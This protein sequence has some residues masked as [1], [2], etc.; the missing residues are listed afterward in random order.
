M[1]EGTTPDAQIV[2]TLDPG[3]QYSL[4]GS[5][6]GSGSVSSS[7]GAFSNA[8]LF[9]PSLVGTI[10]GDGS[11][12]NP[13]VI[14]F[15]LGDLTNTDTNNGVAETLRLVYLATA[16][17]TADNSSH[18]AAAGD[19]KNNAAALTWDLGGASRE[20]TGI[21]SAPTLEIV[22]PELQIDKTLTSTSPVDAGD[23]VSW[24]VSVQ[25][26]AN[27][28]ADAYDATLQDPLPST[29]DFVGLLATHSTLGNVSSLFEFDSGTRQVRTIPGQSFDLAPGE[30]LT[31]TVDGIVN[32][33]AEP[34][35]VI[36][37]QAEVQ[38][39]SLEADLLDGD[40][41]SERNGTGGAVN[42]YLA[43]AGNSALQINSPT[44]SKLL[45]GS[46]VTTAANTAV[47]VALGETAQYRLTLT[48]PEGTTQGAQWFDSLDAGLQFVQVDSVVFSS[49]L[50]SSQATFDPAVIVNGVTFAQSLVFDLGTLTNMD[51]NNSV[52]ETVTID[53]SVRV[54]NVL[55]NQGVNSP[56]AATLLQNSAA[57]NWTVNS[58][59]H[60]LPAVQA[61][62][63][64][65]IEPELQLTKTVD[66]TT[67][68]L[69]ATLTY[70]LSINHDASSST[71]AYDVSLADTLPSFVTLN[72]G[73]ILAVGANI[74]ANASAGN[75]LAITLDSLALGSIAT[76]TY[77]AVV[78]SNPG[79]VGASINNTARMEWT[80]LP[81]S[82][83]TER[84]GSGGALNDY[85]AVDGASA[86]ITQPVLHV[87]KQHTGVTANLTNPL[88]W[89]VAVRVVAMNDGNVDLFNL[90]LLDDLQAHFGA[91]LVSVTAPSV[92][93]SVGLI[94]GGSVP[95][96]NP[97]WDGNLAGSGNV[98]VFNGSS[99][100][101][102]PGEWIAVTFV[103]TMDPDASGAT[104]PLANQVD[105]EADFM[106][107]G[108]TQTVTDPSDSGTNPSG[109]NPGQPG[110]TGGSDD[111]TPLY[112][113]DIA[114]TKS[115]VGVP[116]QLAND[117]FSVTYE[118]ALKNT[119]SVDI[120]D[121]Q[122]TEDMVNEFG[123]SVFV[124][125]LAAPSL[126]G[127]PSQPGSSAATFSSPAWDGNLGASGRVNLFDGSSGRLLP[128]DT[129]LIRFT[130]EV[131]PDAT[132]TSMPLDN[133]VVASATPLDALGNPLPSGTV[134]DLS[135]SGTNPSTTNPST[136]GDSG[137][138]DDPTPLAI[139]DIGLAKQV[140]NVTEVLSGIYDVQY[141]VVLENTGT[142]SVTNLQISEDLVAE[143][144]AA[145]VGIQTAASITSSSLSPGA[146]L[147]G[148]AS[149]AW[150][151]NLAGS[152]NTDFFDGSSGL[153]QP[154]DWLVLTFTARVNTNLGDTTPP[155]D[156]TNQ[157]DASAM[158]PTGLT[159]SD[160]SDDGT[161]P[162]TDNGVGGSDDPSPFTVPM[163][164]ATKS[165]G[166]TTANADGS[167]TV[168]VQILVENS[169]TTVLTDLSLREDITA[170]FGDALI[171]ITNPQI[172]AMGTYTGVL[173]LLN[174]SW[175]GNTT[176]DVLQPT[177]LTES[178]AVGEA[179]VF[180][181]DV[182][183]DPDR[184]DDASQLMFN[185]AL[186]AGMGLNFD[187]NTITVSDVS[188]ANTAFDLAGVD[189]DQPSQLL[190]PE[191]RVAKSVSSIVSVGLDYAVTFAITVENTG[192]AS[193][194]GWN[195]IDDLDAAFGPAFV[196]VDQVTMDATGVGA[197]VA[198]TLNFG[199][200][201]SGTPYDGGQALGSTDLLNGD[202]SLFPGEYFT[203]SLTMTL[204]PESA[205]S[206]IFLNQS[207]AL[208]I[209]P[210]S[211]PV[212]DLSDS[213][214][215]PNT[216][217]PGAVN[218]SGGQDDPT[219]IEISDIA[220][221]K[222][223]VGLP[224]LL[225][226]DHY[227]AVFEITLQNAGTVDVANLQIVENLEAELGSQVFAGVLAAPTL[228]AGTSEV[229]S[230]TPS[231][232]PAWDGG[233][234]A[235]ANVNLFVPS[236]ATRLVP[237]DSLTLQFTIEID[238][239]ASGASR[240]LFNQV[241]ASGDSLGADGSSLGP[242]SD[243]SDSGTNPNSTNAGAPGDL[244]TADD[245]TPVEIPSIRIAKQVNFA[246]PTGITG[247]FD[248]QYVLVVENTGS[249][250]LVSLQL[251]EDLSAEFGL[252]FVALQNVPMFT[253]FSLSPGGALPNLDAA[254]DGTAVHSTLLDGAS[255]NLLP[256]DSFSMT[257]TVRLDAV[258]GDTTAPVDFTNQIVAR[259]DGVTSGGLITVSDLSDDG[260]NPNTNNGM[261]GTN[262]RTGLQSPQVRVGKTYGAITANLDGTYTVP[263]LIQVVNT[264]TA[265]VTDLSLT[266]DL[267]AEFGD[268]F[269]NLLNPQISAI[270]AYAGE[271]PQL[272][273]NWN[274][275]NTSVDIIDPAQSTESLLVGESFLLSFDAVVDPDAVDG[276]SQYLTNQATVAGQST[277]FDGSPVMVVDESGAPTP[278]DIFGADLDNPAQ[279]LI[280]EVRSTKR[281]TMAIPVA[282]MWHV[283][284]EL[285]VENTGSTDLSNINLTDDL[286]AQW[287]SVFSRVISVSLDATDVGLGTAPTLNFGATAGSNPFD[288]GRASAASANLLNGDGLLNPGE[289]VLVTMI[290]AIDP[291]ATGT[292]TMLVNQAQT[293]ATGPTSTV[294]DLSDDGSN[295][296]TDN[297]TAVGDSGTG[298]H[299]DPTPIRIG[300]IAVT[301]E[302]IGTPLRL[303]NGNFHVTYQL[304]VENIGTLDLTH[305]QVIEDLAGH[306]GTGVLVN[307]VAAPAVTSGPLNPMSL[308][309][310][311]TPWD[312]GLGGNTSL[313][314]GT[315]GR[316]VP[317]DG[318]TVEFAVE[319]DPDA[320]GPA[321][322]YFN[323]V[324]ASADDAAGS[325]VTDLSD[326]GNDP[327]T[328]NPTAAGDQGTYDDPTPLVLPGINASKQLV[329]G[330]TILA[331][332]STLFS[333]TYEVQ[334][335]NTGNATLGGLDL[336]DD[337][338]SQFG[339][340][341]L[342]ITAAP[343]I[344]AHTLMSAANLP[345]LNP[346]WTGD[347]S[348]SLF[349]DDGTIH[350][351]ESIT[352]R[353]TVQL[354]SVLVNGMTLLNQAIA[355]ADDPTSGLENGL[356]DLSD[357]GSDPR[358][359]NTGS[360]GDT[361]GY[362]DPTPTI[363][364]NSIVGVAKTSTWD[365]V[366]DRVTFDFYLEHLGV[367]QALQL[368]LQEDLN[369][370]FGAG[371]Y[372]VTAPMLISGP[373]TVS[374]N[375]AYDGQT[376]TELIGA[377]SSMQPGQSAHL[378]ILVTVHQI[379]DVQG[380]GLGFY[381]NQ[382]TIITQNS[383]GNIYMDSSISG[384]DPDPD[385]DGNP[386][387]N[388]WP[389][390][391]SLTPDATVGLAKSGVVSSDSNTITYEF[392]FEHFGNTTALNLTAS[393]DLSAIF[394]VGN[395]S[396]TSIARTAGPATFAANGMY[397]G[398]TD[399]ELI[400][401][402]S[403]LLPGETAVI[404]IVISVPSVP[405]GQYFNTVSVTSFDADG[406]S[407]IDGSQDGLTADPDGNGS[408]TDNSQPTS[409][410]LHR[411]VVS[412]TVFADFNNNGLQDASEPGIPGVQILLTG[413]AMG[414]PVSYA[415]LTEADGTYIFRSLWPGDYTLTEVHPVDFI[416]GRDVV[417]SLGGSTSNDQFQFS[418]PAVDSV[419]SGYNFGELGLNPLAVGKG[420]F[421]G[422]SQGATVPTPP[423][424]EVEEQ[425][426][427]FAVVDGE[428]EI[429][430]VDGDDHVVLDLGSQGFT[431]THNFVRY[432]FSWADVS[433]ITMDAGPGTDTVW[434]TASSWADQL[435]A[436][437]Q[438]IRLTSALYT[439][440]LLHVEH[441]H[442]D[443][444]AGEDRTTLIDSPGNDTFF[445]DATA[446]TLLRSDGSTV[447]LAADAG[448]VRVESIGG[449][450]DRA[451][452]RGTPGADV[453][454][455]R[456]AEQMAIRRHA[457]SQQIV[458]GF[459]LVDAF[460]ND[461]ADRAVFYDTPA[462]DTFEG[463]VDV[464]SWAGNASRH[465]AVGFTATTFLAL[466]GGDDTAVLYGGA[467]V[468]TLIAQ[469]HATQL[470]GVAVTLRASGFRHVQSHSG[471]GAD[472]AFLF[473]SPGT[474]A[475]ILSPTSARLSGAQFDYE[476]LEF[477]RMTVLSE[478]GAGDT[479]RFED[480]PA[481]D[482]LTA[483][484][485]ASVLSGPGYLSQAIL[486]GTVDVFSTAGGRDTA[487]MYDSSGNDEFV[488]GESTAT[489]RGIGFD[490][491]AHHFETVYAQ[492]V[493]GGIDSARLFDSSANDVI[494][495]QSRLTSVRA[496][497][498]SR[499]VYVTAFDHV[500]VTVNAGGQDQLV[501]ADLFTDE[502][503]HGRGQLAE[504]TGRRSFTARG[505][506]SLFANAH[507]GHTPV[508]DLE[509][510]DYVFSRRG[511][512][513]E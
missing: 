167:Y 334:L 274:S 417:G 24:T 382:V 325:S 246:V 371:N 380:N 285:R 379:E 140:N 42:T 510:V 347:T 81:G 175:I 215:N 29:I 223:V 340:A 438:Q 162:N 23:A 476:A 115:V 404:I 204:D 276:T 406:G 64:E 166:G 348:L 322:T 155:T 121:L 301:K 197:G 351:G 288:G 271:L 248:V 232:D 353:Y 71:D 183:V 22:E 357:D 391:G 352:V 73:S 109:T 101:L 383:L 78:T 36:T 401:A 279:L 291:D 47:Q 168:P 342:G 444:G 498:G 361:G 57:F 436:D 499:T 308:T 360:P 7:L 319:V 369:A 15:R 437:Q 79:D 512:W 108:L 92:V 225:A 286:A 18:G 52:A 298:S 388:D 233:F 255:G 312:G 282:D 333:A 180:N 451:T 83:A 368:S 506:D 297:P 267:R 265:D 173:P 20:T 456:P 356:T 435:V 133:Q 194:T 21:A 385:G 441:L 153:L 411:G 479:A 160:V 364:P 262:D 481:D 56:G 144:G 124:G 354:D 446:S 467:G 240:V 172:T 424:P 468:D 315:S 254:W 213:G 245:P 400:G 374:V 189:N 72:T 193:L 326:T 221:V 343:T 214:T 328:Q 67:P 243:P 87:A 258:T 431:L 48:V 98:D 26:T 157:I 500:D 156:Y 281:V 9:D 502:T 224:T 242:V 127:G 485:R 358:G 128:G 170:E 161:N 378:R 80:S 465:R 158:T 362:D 398:D 440:E 209:D 349:Q 320:T 471:G 49:G 392:S 165:Y 370:I 33:S 154:G 210:S 399:A 509:N 222:R 75:N 37:N 69:G 390:N 377:N 143:F 289:S 103:V 70:T 355:A 304:N 202:G 414:M 317:G 338:T 241:T 226:N 461:S 463:R 149:P 420:S 422:S 190:I 188:G 473:G 294:S 134:T 477:P 327:N 200:T 292:S 466:A 122:I 372:S 230:V 483:T 228:I 475:A 253:G 89:D 38:W 54:A 106:D 386:T 184:L 462:A 448:W 14:T 102:R 469:P 505:F 195:L 30:T 429:F 1:P 43:S 164:R 88:N 263:V 207:L 44:S 278:S 91:T 287:G 105:G 4:F 296:N 53:Y 131:D 148:L 50:T 179:Y 300:D 277:N 331:A 314:D 480:S 275:A 293:T 237:G 16:M 34:E 335:M 25:H 239:D 381:Q 395:Y 459:E 496:D 507:S 423:L 82:T 132:G 28:D 449:D 405:A 408:P 495:N 178:L 309:P 66:D 257:F 421:L 216:S 169:G 316:L 247:Q 8:A 305:L 107:D 129:I 199:A 119:G 186:V 187:G 415:T 346:A 416:D 478:G 65:V 117:N 303:P 151:A 120:R 181:F 76:V 208:A 366:T 146:S 261:G 159:V 299:D 142:V 46:S 450:V 61:M 40:E 394:G 244:G 150:D 409:V 185:Q 283:T 256:G 110:D 10:A 174:P 425:F 13:Y 62:S 447:T 203:V 365:D 508:W 19:L 384:T 220:V 442:Y 472:Q 259:G 428:L 321:T 163:I 96:L 443:N 171:S 17:N 306:L 482:Q 264:G 212:S 455:S 152:G 494:T 389:T 238:P 58:S 136:P 31:V 68:R 94:N 268:A 413:T 250:P 266:D 470:N 310:S 430:A 427:L 484:P 432:A 198:P 55:G 137:T 123:S 99:G 426:Q 126:A 85:F 130:V 86:V 503:L 457:T 196:S 41:M 182:R 272:N 35:Q 118:I 227:S 249:V 260:T 90:S 419:A 407:Y 433:R 100:L 63:V 387:N 393:E 464:S 486:F 397:N 410:T 229:G 491:R 231:F 125:V 376:N 453:F 218:D 2:D 490:N 337:L 234:G 84:T 211:N 93:E 145:F 206:N 59:G 290:I 488:A 39:T 345:T 367:V 511:A 269:M 487:M 458:V 205:T 95:G 332:G 270:G 97:V 373:A 12:A 3:L 402:G 116:A 60:A 217:N 418:L 396:V 307:I 147:P 434:L 313:F 492:S 138:A 6:V 114:V 74:T 219:P 113:P 32:V 339:A 504:V 111:P 341:F 363:L 403:S 350:S 474:E 318:L 201:A 135:D 284:L 497:D 323:Q 139:G 104:F 324:Q 344:T 176:L 493:N 375:S 191:L 236:G 501:I 302:V 452:L 192:S 454:V 77:T 445:A 177:Q 311:L 251:T 112:I 141:A 5:L 51:T 11:T 252:G 359:M 330:P 27:S 336:F 273:P 329:S 295:P 513:I 489:L 45:L 412:G 439:V 280:P 460:A 235:S